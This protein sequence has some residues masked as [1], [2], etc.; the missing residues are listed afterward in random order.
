MRT[1]GLSLGLALLCLLCAEAED[2]GAVGLDKSKVSRSIPGKRRWERGLRS[3]GWGLG[4]CFGTGDGWGTCSHH[5]LHC[6][7]LVRAVAHLQHSPAGISVSGGDAGV[8]WPEGVS[9][10]EG[11]TGPA[12][13]SRLTAHPCCQVEG[14][15]HIVALASDSES[16]LQKK[17][18]L[19]MAM[20]TITVLG[21]GDLKVSFA[22]P[23]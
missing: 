19:K 6:H 3:P 13:S 20:A 16:Y 8:L 10:P 1:V 14:K 11:R 2:L 5:Q 7:T 23:T 9:V 17:D 15:W 4:R 22:I 12:G 18:E 21:E